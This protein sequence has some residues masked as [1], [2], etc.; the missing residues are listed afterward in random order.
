[1]PT[2]NQFEI[3]RLRAEV[4]EYKQRYDNLVDG[5]YKVG[6]IGHCTLCAGK[7]SP[8]F[9]T[10]CI[11]KDFPDF[12]HRKLCVGGVV[13]ETLDVDDL[14]TII[15]KVDGNHN[16]G[17]SSLAEKIFAELQGKVMPLVPKGIMPD[18]NAS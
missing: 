16:L 9:Y 3:I 10:G 6:L 18:A 8:G 11:V 15:R 2:N 13:L 12:A 7:E 5:L 14:A 1:M 4:S 17:A